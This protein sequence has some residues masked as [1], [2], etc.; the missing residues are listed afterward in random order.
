MDQ[1]T[2]WRQFTALPRAAQN[3]VTHCLLSAPADGGMVE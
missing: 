3:E 1:E 2:R